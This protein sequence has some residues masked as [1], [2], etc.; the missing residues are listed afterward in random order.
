MTTSACGHSQEIAWLLTVLGQFEA[1][2]SLEVTDHW[3]RL[4]LFQAGVFLDQWL[5]PVP[6]SAVAQNPGGTGIRSG[7][8]G[9]LSLP[10]FGGE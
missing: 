9:A 8:N 1:M 5:G 7:G 4:C 10:G 6:C 3:T 2:D